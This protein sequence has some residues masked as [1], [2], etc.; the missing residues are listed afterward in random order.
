MGHGHKCLILG[1]QERLANNPLQAIRAAIEL[2][3]S[4][5]RICII[6]APN[7]PKENGFQQIK[8]PNYQRPVEAEG[9]TLT[10][11][12]SAAIIQT[13]DCPTVILTD[14]ATGKKVVTHAGRPALTPQENCIDRTIVETALAQ[15]GARDIKKVQ[16]FVLGD[17]C[18]NCFLH[19]HE[20]AL[21]LVEP[22]LRL[23]QSVFTN[24]ERNGLS[25]FKVI[26]ARLMH[27]GVPSAN[28][29]H[30]NDCTFEH[31]RYSSHRRDS[32]RNDRNHVIVVRVR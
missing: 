7:G 12:G 30:Y 15:L 10:E 9:I 28:I 19:D 24:V 22:F 3:A 32:D 26:E 6:H 25:L 4:H 17:I 29:A 2:G 18:G 20:S 27:A 31:H 5:E 16:A 8:V 1:R 11:Q 14:E 23:G 21:P 13:A